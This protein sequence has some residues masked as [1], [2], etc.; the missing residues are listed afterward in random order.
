MVPSL[1]GA[2]QDVKSC[3]QI[4]RDEAKGTKG[5]RMPAVQLPGGGRV[6]SS[7]RHLLRP[8]STW[9]CIGSNRTQPLQKL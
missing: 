9:V 2:T 6:F 4:R 5:G 1:I 8:P 3:V 7:S